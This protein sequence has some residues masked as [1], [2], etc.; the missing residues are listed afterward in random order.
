MLLRNAASKCSLG[1]VV[2]GIDA[3]NMFEKS[4][5]KHDGTESLVKKNFENVS[6]NTVKKPLS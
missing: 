3:Q 4:L 2:P 6:Q 1:K 5:S